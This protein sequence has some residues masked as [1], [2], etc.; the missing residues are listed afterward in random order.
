MAVALV[1]V[2]RPAVTGP[3][4]PI[5]T[6]IETSAEATPVVDESNADSRVSVAAA[7]AQDLEKDELQQA[8]RPSA[9]AAGA[10][11]EDL[12]ADQRQA[13]ARLI[14]SQMIGAE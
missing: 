11:L 13:L 9:D 3:S 1:V 2:L 4:A 12:T 7:V 5:V 6:P 8:L 10:A 14:K